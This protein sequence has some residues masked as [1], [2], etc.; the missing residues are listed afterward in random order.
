MK[1]LRRPMRVGA[2]TLLAGVLLA[3]L[4][5]RAQAPNANPPPAR[6]KLI[7]VIVV[8]QMRADYIERF[9][10]RWRGGLRRLVDQ[11]A[12]LRN[13]AYP[14]TATET[15]PGHATISTGVFPAIHGIVGNAWWD[16]QTSARL[17]CT[18]DSS[19]RK[20]GMA[21]TTASGDSAAR[22]LA[23]SFAEQLRTAVPGSRVVTISV[24]ARSSIMLAGHRAD[25]VLWMDESTGELLTSSAYGAE[26]PAFAREMV[27]ANPPA[28]D[29]SRV[30]GLAAPAATYTGGRSVAGEGPPAGWKTSF[31]HP[32][33]AG[34]KTP[35]A[36]FFARWRTSPFAD[37]YLERL[38]T[39]AVDDMKLGNGSGV[40]FLGVGFSA[41]D[42]VGHSFGPD[43]RE[44]E[45]DLLALDKTVAALLDKLD[46]SA[47]AGQYVVALTADHGVAPI[48]EQARAQGRDAGRVDARSLV[49]RIEKALAQKLGAGKYVARLLGSDLYFAPGVAARLDSDA[50]LWG[51][52][53]R[54]ALSEPGV[55]RLVLRTKPAPASATDALLRALALD[56]YPQR[57]GDVWISLKRNW[58]F[59]AAAGTTHG[60][61]YDYDQRVPIVLFGA[62]IK[63]GRYTMSATP[64]DIAPTLASLAGVRINRTDGR[65]LREALRTPPPLPA[66]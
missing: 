45:D 52:V 40:D 42:Y 32:L 23:P 12:W 56:R 39:A 53:Q 4:S 62:G 29:F 25:T 1:H 33:S 49:A 48:P 37:A 20:V 64:A 3:V 50:S 10:D 46:R 44:M 6:P 47:G 58:I 8:D 55:D 18:Q 34:E 59:S 65:I 31:P 13:A 7:V 17:T 28:A 21:R 38:A 27:G 36:A 19:A 11:G 54:A 61:A 15:C 24:K 57:S 30:W 63:P 66:R 14:Y 41:P 51:D 16:R 22:L 5:M 9:R 43:S 35:G 2:V 60:S 26:I